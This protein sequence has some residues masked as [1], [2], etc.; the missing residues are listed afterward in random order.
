MD[1]QLQR[2][3]TIVVGSGLFGSSCAK[4]LSVE[5]DKR[6]CLIGPDEPGDRSDTTVCDQQSYHHSHQ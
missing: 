1:F 4:H 2:F 6:V 5:R 3:D